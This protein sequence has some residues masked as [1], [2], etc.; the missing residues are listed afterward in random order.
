MGG[1]GAKIR[2]KVQTLDFIVN[3]MEYHRIILSV[4]VHGNI[5]AVKTSFWGRYVSGHN[6]IAAIKPSVPQMTENAGKNIKK[7]LP[8]DNGKRSKLDRFW[9]AV[10]TS[11]RGTA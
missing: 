11:K 1:G 6:Q 7:Q 5:Y 4:C 10:S 8:E 3:A 2:E 9:R